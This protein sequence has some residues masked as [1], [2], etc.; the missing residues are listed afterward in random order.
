[1]LM[2]RSIDVMGYLES[3]CHTYLQQ[4]ISSCSKDFVPP[5]QILRSNR[6]QRP[7]YTDEK[8]FDLA[9]TVNRTLSLETEQ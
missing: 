8:Y 2:I 3:W 5:R 6:Q 1:M 7:V 4:A 9:S